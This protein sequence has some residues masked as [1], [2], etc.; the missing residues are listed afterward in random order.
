MRFTNKPNLSTKVQLYTAFTLAEVLITL[1]IIGVVA[2]MTIPAILKN[3][4]PN[5]AAIRGLVIHVSIIFESDLMSVGEPVNI[6]HPIIA[7]TTA[8]EVDTGNLN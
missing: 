6:F 7:P 8:C 4:K 2:A 1:G 5:K 3:T